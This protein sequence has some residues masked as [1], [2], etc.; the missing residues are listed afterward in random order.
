[1]LDLLILGGLGKLFIYLTQQ[2][3]PIKKIKIEFFKKLFECDLC[4][5][6]WVYLTIFSLFDYE[7]VSQLLGVK[8]ILVNHILTAGAVSFAVHLMSLGWKL[9]FGVFDDAS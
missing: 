3:Y 4:L 5:G 7:L 1:M 2:F 6:F 9:K 8:V